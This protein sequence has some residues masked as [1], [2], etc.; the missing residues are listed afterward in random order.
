MNSP[1]SWWIRAGDQNAG[2]AGRFT[3]GTIT[4]I[5]VISMFVMVR[6]RELVQPIALLTLVLVLVYIVVRGTM[7]S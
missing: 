5:F 6:R 1:E 7:L 4:I 2:S 3:G